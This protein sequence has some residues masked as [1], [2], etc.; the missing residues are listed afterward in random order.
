MRAERKMLAALTA[1]GRCK[2]RK[3]LHWIR[4]VRYWDE[5]RGC[6]KLKWVKAT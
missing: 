1:Y 3:A 5:R 6:R 4:R 2:P